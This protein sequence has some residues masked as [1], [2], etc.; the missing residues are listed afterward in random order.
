MKEEILNIAKKHSYAVKVRRSLER[1]NTDSED[2]LDI[3][4]WSLQAML[5]KAYEL[6]RQNKNPDC[7][8]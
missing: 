4:V 1:R 7:T 3:S 5:E 8:K 2:F 6:G